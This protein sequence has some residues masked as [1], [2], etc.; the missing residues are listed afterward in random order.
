MRG[1]V[2]QEL[3]LRVEVSYAEIVSERLRAPS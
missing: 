3:R 1:A 2:W